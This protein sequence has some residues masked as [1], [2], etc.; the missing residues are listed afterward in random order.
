MPRLRQQL[1]RASD[2]SDYSATTRPVPSLAERFFEYNWIDGAKTLEHYN[3][4]GYP[5]VMIGDILHKRHRVVDKLG[6]GGYSTTGIA[7]S[8]RREA[9]VLRY[10]SKPVQSEETHPGCNLTPILLDEFELNGPNGSH[11]CYTTTLT[12]QPSLG[13]I[14]SLISSRRYIH[15]DPPFSIP[16]TEPITQRD[17]L[18][19]PPNLPPKAVIPIHL[20]KRSHKFTLSDVRITEIRLGRD[21]HSPLGW[22]PPLA[23]TIWEV[24]CMKSIV[25]TDF[26]LP[27]EVISVELFGPLPLDWWEKWEE[28]SKF[29]EATGHLLGNR[30]PWGSLGEGF[31]NHVQKYWRED[32]V[33]ELGEDEA[34]AILDLMRRMLKFRPGERISADEVLQSEWMVKWALPAY[35]KTLDGAAEGVKGSGNQSSS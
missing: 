29:F 28:R 9:A 7:D 35:E 21:C 23:P 2:L 14:L 34:A 27:D 8:P 6:F 17:G 12:L 20:G 13:I 10:L 32:D 26:V 16:E 3:P 4:G 33:G 24:I 5:P 18:L 11:P 19:I 15:E 31:E 22:Y 25:S 1:C 30:Y